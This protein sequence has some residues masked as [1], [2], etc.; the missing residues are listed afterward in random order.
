MLVSLAR[1][2][3]VAV[4][5][6]IFNLPFSAANEL[7]LT[8]KLVSLSAKLQLKVLVCGS[9]VLHVVAPSSDVAVPSLLNVNLLSVTQAGTEEE[10]GRSILPSPVMSAPISW[11]THA[12]AVSRLVFVSAGLGSESFPQETQSKAKARSSRDEK[13]FIINGFVLV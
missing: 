9:P 7:L 6:F 10:S 3:V 4:S 5:A 13:I 2:K 8:I 12:E 11:Y 1:V